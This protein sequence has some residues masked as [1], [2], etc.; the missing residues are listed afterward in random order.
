MLYH[1]YEMHRASLSPLNA[2]AQATRLALQ[3]PMVPASYTPAGRAIAA[4]A[5]LIERTTRRY[6]KPEFGL[7][8]TIVNG[9]KVKVT[10][11]VLGERPFCRLVHFVR[12]VPRNHKPDPQVLVAAP[13]SGHHA[14]LLRGTVEALLP[15][16]DVYITDW[17]DARMVPLR[18]GDF[19]LDDY[20]DYLIDFMRGLGPETH[21]IA[22][23]QPAVP[24]LCAVALMAAADDPA[25]P[26]SMTLMG[27]PIDVRKAPTT[28]TE[29][30]HK[31]PISWFRRNVVT[32]VPPPYPGAL[33]KVYPGFLQLAG[34]MSMNVESHMKEHLN[35]FKHLIEGDGDGASRHRKFYDEYLAVMD[36]PARFYLDTVEHV[37]Q[38]ASLPRGELVIR[39][40]RVNPAAIRRTALMTIEGEFDDISAPGQTKAAHELCKSLPNH[41]RGHYVQ[42]GVGHYGI[43]NGRKWREVILP[44]VSAFIRRFDR[45]AS[46]G[47]ITKRAADVA[48]PPRTRKIKR[49]AKA[50]PSGKPQARPA[51]K[52][53][54]KKRTT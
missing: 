49:L 45:P 10:E 43:F 46:L 1:L 3:H 8:S 52:P 31:H 48:L 29:F 20:I 26:R 51:R 7:D 42:E 33:R 2:V 21:I 4:G 38:N 36:I 6:E 11:E 35:L 9:K 37:F 14:T 34:F 13:M 23:C 47:S 50:T 41:M 16:H 44:K 25:Q 12:D 39:G 24:V 54:S 5:E 17:L 19:G 53:T 18:D 32:D 27:G 40:K 22:V 28:V 15:D 30:G